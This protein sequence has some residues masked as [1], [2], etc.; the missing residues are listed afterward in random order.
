MV[1]DALICY[2]VLRFSEL[3]KYDQ[4]KQVIDECKASYR[5]APRICAD[6]KCIVCHILFTHTLNV[7]LHVTLVLFVPNLTCIFCLPP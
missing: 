7:L 2:F 3:L 5:R 1:N 6:V 4:S